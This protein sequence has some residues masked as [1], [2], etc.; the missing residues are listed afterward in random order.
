MLLAFARQ[1]EHILGSRPRRSGL[2]AGELE[3]AAPRGEDAAAVVADDEAGPGRGGSRP[4]ARRGS[5]AARR[6]A[7]ALVGEV[8]EAAVTTPPAFGQMKYGMPR[9]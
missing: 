6:A 9:S 7:D 2:E 1:A 8:L 3:H 5:E 4:S